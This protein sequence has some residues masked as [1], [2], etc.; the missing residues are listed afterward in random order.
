MNEVDDAAQDIIKSGGHKISA[1]EIER[2]SS[3]QLHILQVV[4]RVPLTACHIFPG[5]SGAPARLLGSS[6][7]YT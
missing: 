5:T 3:C 7:R 4:H 2:V 6:V 1:L